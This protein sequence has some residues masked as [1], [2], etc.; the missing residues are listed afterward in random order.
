MDQLRTKLLSLGIIVM[1]GLQVA[2]VIPTLDQL[3]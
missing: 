3:S 1:H 2:P